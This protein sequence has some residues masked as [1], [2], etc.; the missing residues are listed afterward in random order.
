M[1]SL[2]MWKLRLRATL[3]LEIFLPLG[4][5]SA[6]RILVFLLTHCVFLEELV[7]LAS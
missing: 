2:Q 3:G 4:L 7:R 6:V 1:P 5:G